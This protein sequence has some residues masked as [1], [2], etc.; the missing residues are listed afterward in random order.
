L[1]RLIQEFQLFRSE[2]TTPTVIPLPKP[3]RAS[4]SA[5]ASLSEPTST[6]L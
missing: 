2:S 4:V 3:L 6:A 1:G 5:V